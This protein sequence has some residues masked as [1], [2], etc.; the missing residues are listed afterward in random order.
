MSALAVTAE[1]GPCLRL[2][3]DNR[4]L[5]FAQSKRTTTGR[6][7][8]FRLLTPAEQYAALEAI[9]NRTP[10]DDGHWSKA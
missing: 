2:L 5:Y 9:D 7:A 3:S 6:A 4:D 1:L 8:P 10:S